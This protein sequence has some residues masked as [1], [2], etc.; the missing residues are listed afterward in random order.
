MHAGPP[1]SDLSRELPRNV[2]GETAAVAE[3]LSREV[4]SV[5]QST[6]SRLKSNSFR[7]ETNRPNG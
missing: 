3:M 7:A 4:R 1:F 6:Q 2:A 5:M